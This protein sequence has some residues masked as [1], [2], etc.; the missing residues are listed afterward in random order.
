M[1]IEKNKMVSLIYE[2]RENDPEGRIIESLDENKPLAFIFGTGKLLPAFESNINSLIKGDIFRFTMDSE[3]AYGEKREEMIVN[4]PIA[5]FETDGK[6][7]EDICQVGNDVP[8]MD[9][10]GNPLNG[11]I[12]EIADTYVKMDFNHPMAGLDLFFS[13]KI[14]DVRDAA[15]EE[16]AGMNHSCSSCGNISENGCPGSCS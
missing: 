15:I 11:I 9:T 16:I 1:K 8:M 10:E 2:L 3:M 7:N 14:I 4:V 6:L 5:V 13:G 12:N